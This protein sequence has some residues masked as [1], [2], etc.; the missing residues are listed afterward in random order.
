MIR[1]LE[2]QYCHGAVNVQ[3]DV[4]EQLVFDYPLLYPKGE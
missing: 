4:M 1:P 3:Y 2:N